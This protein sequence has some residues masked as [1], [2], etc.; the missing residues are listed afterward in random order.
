MADQKENVDKQLAALR[1]LIDRIPLENLRLPVIARVR[2]L[3]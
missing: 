3:T 1:D 2:L